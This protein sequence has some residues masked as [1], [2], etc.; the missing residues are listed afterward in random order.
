MSSSKFN[1]EAKDFSTI[2]TIGT[3]DGVHLGHQKIL[4]ILVSKSTALDL[5]PTVLTL[6]PHPRMVLQ[7]D[8]PIKL[9][10]TIDERIE[11][12]QNFGIENVVVKTFSK[13]FSN[14]SPR[15]YVKTILVDEL[16]VGAVVIGYDHHFG[17]NRSAN[18]DDLKGFGQEFNFQIEEISAQDVDDITISSTKIRKALNSGQVELANSF[19][20]Y[21]FFITGQVVKGEQLG[22]TLGFPTANIHIKE[23]YKLIPKDGVYIVKALIEAE[24]VFGMMNIGSKPTLGKNQRSI[25]VHFFNFD[26]DLYA[27]NI[28]VEFLK[29]LRDEEKFNSMGD[30]K[31]QL[32]K[33]KDHALK[34]IASLG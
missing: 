11:I 6:F 32:K 21:N 22:R 23:E 28:R 8:Q 5:I 24:E 3:F 7:P 34:Y 1:T 15:D 17:K 18:I 2:T 25:E 29:R 10:H 12:L 19:L 27:K 16:N 9:L 30:L 31:N 26:N 4:K 14:L 20:D 13:E 33:D